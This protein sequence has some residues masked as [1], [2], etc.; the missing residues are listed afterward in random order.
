MM[1]PRTQ[2]DSRAALRQISSTLGIAIHMESRFTA[3]F[4]RKTPQRGASDP[5]A[6]AMKLHSIA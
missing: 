2:M 3:H 5:M 6:R 4:H 1:N